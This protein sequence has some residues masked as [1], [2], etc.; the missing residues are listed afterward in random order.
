MPSPPSTNRLNDDPKPP[1]GPPPSNVN[2][3]PTQPAAPSVSSEAR[4]NSNVGPP[5]IPAFSRPVRTTRNKNPLYV[6]AMWSASIEELRELNA[7]ISR[8]V[9]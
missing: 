6:D 7:S 3:E 9:A 1:V 2:N 8:Q 4:E 5:P